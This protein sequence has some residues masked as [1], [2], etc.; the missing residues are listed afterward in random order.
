MAVASGALP[1]GRLQTYKPAA[2]AIELVRRVGEQPG[3]GGS[4]GFLLRW[5]FSIPLLSRRIPRD[6]LAF[7]V[8]DPRMWVRLM[9]AVPGS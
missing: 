7:C 8:E 6:Q 2:S 4:D 3:Q 1:R 9:V 5:L